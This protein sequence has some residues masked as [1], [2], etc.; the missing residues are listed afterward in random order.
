MGATKIYGT[1]R[2]QALLDRVKALSP[3]RIEVFSLDQA[4]LT[5]KWI[6]RMTGGEGVD[7]FIDC[8]GPGAPHPTFQ[9]G[10]RSLKR[11]G[12]QQSLGGSLWFDAGEGQDMADMAASGLVDLSVFEQVAFPLSQVNEAISGIENRNGGFSNYVINP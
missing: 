3:Q 6:E 8:L 9:A 11:G 5:D 10:M 7:I 4:E 12:L 1:A 2:N